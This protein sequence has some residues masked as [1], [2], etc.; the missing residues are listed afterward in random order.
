MPLFAD[1]ITHCL[2]KDFDLTLTFAVSLCN[3]VRDTFSLNF[4]TFDSL[5]GIGGVGAPQILLNRDP[6]FVSLILSVSMAYSDQ[7]QL[8]EGH[9]HGN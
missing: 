7:R 4:V 2:Q 6:T 3:I 1:G 9:V 5:G 8:M